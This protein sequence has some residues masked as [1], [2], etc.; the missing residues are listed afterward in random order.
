MK[1]GRDDRA[2]RIK[3]FLAF[4]GMQVLADFGDAAV[5]DAHVTQRI[6]SADGSTRR[7]PWMSTR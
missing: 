4:V 2:T 1:P 3:R 5:A 6:E 7:P